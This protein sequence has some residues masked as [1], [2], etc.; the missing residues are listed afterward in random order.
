MGPPRGSASPVK[1]IHE[2]YGEVLLG[3]DKPAEAV[4][5]FEATLR[6]MPNR[7]LSLLGLAR[8]HSELGHTEAAR[9]TYT[10]LVKVWREHQE[11]DGF[12][13]AHSFVDGSA[14]G[15]GE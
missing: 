9:E 7:P 15:G 13:E 8:A 6:L 2:L 12:G 4:E 10:K 14:T 3:Q 11:L 1:P 5:H